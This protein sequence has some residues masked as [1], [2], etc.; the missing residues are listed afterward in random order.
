[1]YGRALFKNF[2]LPTAFQK[3]CFVEDDLCMCVFKKEV[4]LIGE[5][6]KYQLQTGRQEHGS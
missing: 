3:S 5:L 6:W 1:M 4:S 2:T